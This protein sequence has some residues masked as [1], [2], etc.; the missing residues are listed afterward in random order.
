VAANPVYVNLLRGAATN[1]ERQELLLQRGMTRF[2]RREYSEALGWFEKAQKIGTKSPVGLQATFYHAYALSR[3]GRAEE[4]TAKYRALIKQDPKRKSKWA[5]EAQFKLGLIAS[6]ERQDKQAIQDFQ[7]YLKQYADG[8][9]RADALWWLAMTQYN[10]KDY[11]EARKAFAERAGF[12][13][14]QSKAASYWVARCDEHLGRRE[15]AYASY[16]TI[17]ANLPLH[18]YGLLAAA[19]LGMTT[20]PLPAR[21]L[22]YAQDATVTI[23]ATGRYHL[24][25]GNIL[26]ELTRFAD[27]EK[28]YLAAS[29]SA[30]RD[31][32]MV[33]ARALV[34]IG[35]FNTSQRMIWAAFEPEL[36]RPTV[37]YTD[38]WELAYP[39][40][41]AETVLTQAKLQGTNPH[42]TLALMREESRYK[43]DVSSP[44]DAFGLLQLILPTAK[45]VAASMG[46]PVPSMGDLYQPDVNIALGTAYIRSLLDAY[47]NN[48]FLAFAGYNGGPKNVNRWL[49]ERSGLD[50]DEFVENIP[51][52]ETRNYV[53]KVTTSLLRYQYL[54]QPD[55]AVSTPFLTASVRDTDQANG[56][57]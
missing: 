35:R 34:H 6:Q 32:V 26:A 44:A 23:D 52:S 56:V 19:R 3:L 8:D 46:K 13:D 25:R 18:Y 4:A 2:N 36:L 14:E 57:E 1:G 49:G 10:Q 7:A 51:Y 16:A 27:A 17:A 15:Q 22:Y 5:A 50:L 42:I 28:E 30:S 37:F 31:Q 9:Q 12:S 39:K 41:F 21:M 43:P 29:Q 53:K 11:A 33:A 54:Y 55:T 20:R 38:L 24:D 47:K 48:F 45:R 40:A